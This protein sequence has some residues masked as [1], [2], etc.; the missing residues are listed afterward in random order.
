MTLIH[1][2]ISLWILINANDGYVIYIPK[3]QRLNT[4]LAHYLAF[5]TAWMRNKYQKRRTLIVV[6]Y[7]T[8]HQHWELHRQQNTVRK[9]R[10]AA[11]NCNYTNCMSGPPPRLEAW[12]VILAMETRMNKIERTSTIDTDSKTIGIDNSCSAYI[13]G[14]AEDFQGLLEPTE[15]VIK[16]FGGTCTSKVLK[17]TAFLRIENDSGKIH[18]FKIPNSYFVPGYRVRLLSPQHWAQELCRQKLGPACSKTTMN[19]GVLSSKNFI[20]TIRLETSTNAKRLP[21]MINS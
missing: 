9:Y 6:K 14:Y 17:G 12:E 19:N 8:G 3:S 15:Q 16:G 2:V 1:T 21:T 5:L 20:K 13:S 11:P 18:D 10:T 4:R 7:Q